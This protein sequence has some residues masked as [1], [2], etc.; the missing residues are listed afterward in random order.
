MVV[1]EIFKSGHTRYSISVAP[2]S[3]SCLGL[4]F[5]SSFMWDK[6]RL[7][8][9]LPFV[10]LPAHFKTTHA[11]RYA[12]IA[13]KSNENLN[14]FVDFQLFF[15]IIIGERKLIEESQDHI[16]ETFCLLI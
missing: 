14:K 13:D 3:L 7:R 6:M 4:F 10:L 11:H 2:S 16:L 9:K 5:N 15:G 1:F 12:I 8:Y